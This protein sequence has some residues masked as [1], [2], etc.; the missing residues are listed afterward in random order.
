MGKDWKKL[1][2]LY[3]E[4]PGLVANGVISEEA[5]ASIK[6][7]YGE[8]DKSSGLRLLVGAFAVLGA[9]LIGSGV[10]LILAHNWDSLGREARALVSI[11]PS[12]FGL[13]C[14][15]WLVAK[16]VSSR[17]WTEAVCGF[18]TLALGSSM[19]LV[20]QT[21]NSG[22]DLQSLLFSWFVLSLPLAFLFDSAVCCALG[23]VIFTSFVTC[24][25]AIGGWM[26]WTM[27]ALAIPYPA[28]TLWRERESLKGVFLGWA[29]AI[30]STVCVI[31]ICVDGRVNE[32]FWSLILPCFF[33]AIYLAGFS[34][35]GDSKLP[36]WRAPLK[37]LGA[38]GAL[39]MALIFSYPDSWR[40][41]HGCLWWEDLGSMNSAIVLAFLLGAAATL[42][43]ARLLFKKRYLALPFGLVGPLL[44]ALSSF[45]WT[46]S[47]FF[48]P[49]SLLVNALILAMGVCC[50]VE[51][52]RK[53][54]L[55]SV[56]CGLMILSA[57]ILCR[58]FNTDFSFLARGIAFIA[59]GAAFLAA[60]LIMLKRRRAA[61]ADGR[62]SL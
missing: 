57:L 52:V 62:A 4:L 24:G 23:L 35:E 49:A 1:A 46:H 8:P 61:A 42:S 34:L 29:V 16:R 56:N 20:G 38:T 3:S 39:V 30:A 11:A 50:L 45:S 17:A 13:L 6:L 54:T 18:Q 55:G 26:F 59:L 47:G 37:A 28:W 10:I 21:Y 19:A 31:A 7:H 15:A 60:N 5:A 32:S 44:F 58:F 43:L 48:D 12:A 36:A 14:L 9:L 22:G 41:S 51:G 25:N 2:W 27:L 40:F 53:E 33:S